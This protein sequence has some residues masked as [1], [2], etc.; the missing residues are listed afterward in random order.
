MDAIHLTRGSWRTRSSFTNGRGG[1][2]RW[3]CDW[4]S[5]VCS[6]DLLLYRFFTL[7]NLSSIRRFSIN[8]GDPLK[9]TPGLLVNPPMSQYEGAWVLIPRTGNFNEIHDYVKCNLDN[10]ECSIKLL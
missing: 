8:E 2:R 10:S 1:N 4:S 9:K 5:D 6:S 3:N 7:T